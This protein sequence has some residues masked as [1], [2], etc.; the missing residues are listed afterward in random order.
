M[1]LLAC[2]N[3]KSNNNC[4]D[5]NAC[6]DQINQNFA[7]QHK[8]HFTAAMQFT[9]AAMTEQ[10]TQGIDDPDKIKAMEILAMTD[11]AKSY[12]FTQIYK[13]SANHCDPGV[14]QLLTT[15][16]DV[17]SHIISLGEYYYHHGID[18]KI[19]DQDFSKSGEELTAGLTQM[20]DQL[21]QEHTA[22][23][24]RQKEAECQAAKQALQS[25]A[26]LY[27]NMP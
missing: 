3:N 11:A 2:A 20:T 13:V 5:K 7:E 23:N 24:K 27:G 6:H 4:N 15:Y 21:D 25:L 22:A 18:A 16:K 1:Q 19:G 17:A 10:K 9:L 14:E 8:A 26:Y 12:A